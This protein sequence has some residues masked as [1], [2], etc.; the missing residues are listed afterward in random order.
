MP[1]VL[2][3]TIVA[4]V[5]LPVLVP[6]LTVADLVS[7]RRRLPRLRVY[8]FLVQYLANDSVEIVL[9]PVLWMRAGLGTRLGSVAS[10]ERHRRLQ[11][12]SLDLLARRADRLLG[13]PVVL[14]PEAE[15]ALGPGPVVVIAR[16]ASLFDASLPA[17]VYGRKGFAVRGVIMAEMLADPGFDLLYGRLG[18]VFIPRDDAPAARAAIEAMAH[19]ITRH[20]G[21][22]SMVGIYPEGRLFSPRARDG[23]LDRLAKRAPERA[24]RLAGLSNLLPPRPGGLRI[25]LDALP[26]ADV[27][28]LDHRGL[29]GVGSLTDLVAM[30]PATEPVTVSARRHARAT[31]PDDLDEFTA[32]LDERWLELD[33]EIEAD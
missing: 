15:A 23:A 9:V 29:D 33:A 27:V 24:E 22:D 18:S 21:P 32:W 26:D 11:W 12:W 1:A 16:H 31:I 3:A 4:V 30:V 17:L 19:S 6:A 13:L 2:A 28:V 25:L 8:L 7:G 10:I 5:G 14:A 20:D